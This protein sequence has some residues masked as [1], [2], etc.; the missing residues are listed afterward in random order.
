MVK[1]NWWKQENVPSNVSLED[2]THQNSP[3]EP[4][5]KR[6]LLTVQYFSAHWHSRIESSFAWCRRSMVEASWSLD[7]TLPI[8]VTSY[9]GK[10]VSRAPAC[11]SSLPDSKNCACSHQYKTGRL[12]K[13]TQK[14]PYFSKL[15]YEDQNKF[16]LQRYDSRRTWAD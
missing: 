5:Q 16:Y 11:S 12:N 8:L 13:W 6:N 10:V 2:T 3:S 15:S 14:H 9:C 7:C 1:L 4:M